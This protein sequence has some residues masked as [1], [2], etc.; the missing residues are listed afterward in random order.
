MTETPDIPA[1]KVDTGPIDF[2]TVCLPQGVTFASEAEYLRALR[3]IASD[4]VSEYMEGNKKLFLEA[5]LRYMK[6]VGC[7]DTPDNRR[8]YGAAGVNAWALQMIDTTAVQ[9]RR[10]AIRPPSRSET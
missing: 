8:E 3:V 7:T 1:F 6:D 2:G 4:I 5:T 10:S 9:L